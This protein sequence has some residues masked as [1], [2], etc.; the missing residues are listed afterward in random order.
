VNY[1]VKFEIGQYCLTANGWYLNLYLYVV[2]GL[3]Q[4]LLLDL[5]GIKVPFSPYQSIVS[6]SRMQEPT[7]LWILT[8]KD[9][10]T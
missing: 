5:Q 2:K 10:L 1:L 6:E 4:V 3:Q 9:E 7:I 8:A